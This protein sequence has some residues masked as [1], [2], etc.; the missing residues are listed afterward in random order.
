MK[1]DSLKGWRRK[2][3][4]GSKQAE[5]SERRGCTER[6]GLLVGS[7]AIVCHNNGG[8]TTLY[9]SVRDF[10]KQLFPANSCSHL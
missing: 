1:E 9:I 3:Y 5:G 2:T 4:G 8:D 6:I 7:K 10:S